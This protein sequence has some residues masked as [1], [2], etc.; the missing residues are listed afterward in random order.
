MK[1][2][3]YMQLSAMMGR[4]IEAEG[5]RVLE[6]RSRLKRALF[7]LDAEIA[8]MP[9]GEPSAVTGIR[10][11]VGCSRV[12]GTLTGYSSGPRCEDCGVTE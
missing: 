2:V 3:D 8:E 4:D 5:L 1:L 10:H 9:L 6:V 12:D 7:T 11:R